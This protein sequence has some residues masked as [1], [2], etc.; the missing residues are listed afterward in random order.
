MTDSKRL[1]IEARTKEL[2]LAIKRIQCGRSRTNAVKLTITSVA[3]EAGVST[4]LIHNIYPGIAEIIREIQ[5]RSS[6]AQRD[7]KHQ[8]LKAERDKLH[9]LRVELRAAKA[10]IAD[11]AS[12]NEVLSAENEKLKAM[13]TAGNVRAFPKN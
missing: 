9:A 8:K 4:A 13:S 6:R 1:S 7:A 5:G 11:L 3:R 12:I 2:H 10:M